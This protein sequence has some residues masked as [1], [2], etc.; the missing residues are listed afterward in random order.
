MTPSQNT[1]FYVTQIS[2]FAPCFFGVKKTNKGEGTRIAYG[3]L[4]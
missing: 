1:T 3:G 4:C 2:S